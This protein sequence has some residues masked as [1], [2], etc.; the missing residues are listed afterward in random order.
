MTVSPDSDYHINTSSNHS[1][2]IQSTSSFSSRSGRTSSSPKRFASAPVSAPLFATGSGSASGGAGFFSLGES[3]IAERA[4]KLKEERSKSM[5]SPE[6]SGASTDI[7]DDNVSIVSRDESVASAIFDKASLHEFDHLLISNQAEEPENL[8]HQSLVG[9]FQRLTAQRQDASDAVTDEQRR[10]SATINFI[11]PTTK[12]KIAPSPASAP[13]MLAT[14]ASQ[15]SNLLQQQS[16]LAKRVGSTTS[17]A[18]NITNSPPLIENVYEKLTHIFKQEYG[19][20]LRSVQHKNPRTGETNTVRSLPVRPVLTMAG[21]NRAVA[22]ESTAWG[23][24]SGMMPV[25]DPSEWHTGPLCHVYIAACENVDHYRTKV[26]PSLKVFVSQLESSESNMTANQ[27]GGHSA[28]YLIVYVPLGDSGRT[29]TPKDATPSASKTPTTTGRLGFFGIG[30]RSQTEGQGDNDD[31]SKNSVDSAEIEA[32]NNDDSD[33]EA[34]GLNVLMALNHL[35]KAERALYKKIVTNFPNG[36]VC[37]LSTES[38]EK[39]FDSE[40]MLATRVQE[41]NVF[42]RLLGQV[43]VNGFHDRVRRYKAELKRLD[44]QRASAATAAKNY[45][46]K[47]GSPLKP[48]PY[49]FNLSHF[50]LVKESLAFS[51]EQ[52]QLPAEALLQ[53]DEFRLY[54]PDLTDKEERKVRKA[55]RKSKALTDEK[56][57]AMADAGDFLGFRKRIRTE[58]DLTAILDIMRRYLFARE[59]SLLF[60]MENP[61]EL[62]IR[63]QAFVKVMYSIVLRG[64]SDLDPADQKERTSRAATWVVQFSWDICCAAREYLASANSEEPS[65]QK[66]DEAAAA[67]LSDILEVARLFLIQLAKDHPTTL[68]AFTKRRKNFPRDFLRPWEPWKPCE[69]PPSESSTPKAQTSTKDR[70][71]LITY[72]DIQTSLERFDEAYLQLCGVIIDSRQIAKHHRL[73][74]RIQAEV[75]EY[76]ASKGDLVKAAASFSKIVKMYRLDH[77]DRSHF[78]RVFRLAYCQRTSVEPTLYLKT[79][80]SCFSPRSAVVAPKRALEALFEDLKKVIEHP[81][82]G[83]ARYSRLLFIETSLSVEA[84]K[85]QSGRILDQ[86]EVEKRICSVGETLKL[87]FSIKSHLPGAIELTSVKL[88]AVTAE[89]FKKILAK[90]DAVQE[91]DAAKVLSLSSPIQINP[92]K[93]DFAFEWS[94]PRSGQYILSTVEILWKQGYFY[95]DSM[96]LQEPLLSI[97][98]EPN[99]PTHSISMEPTEL[100]PGHDQEVKISFEAGADVVSS[101]KLILSG[102]DGIQLIPPNSSEWQQDW[103]ADLDPLKPGQKHEITAQVRCALN[104]TKSS[105]DDS[106]DDKKRGLFAKALTS[107]LYAPTAEEEK[108]ETMESTLEAFSPLLEKPTLS[109][110]SVETQWIQANER[111]L[112]SIVVASNTQNQYVVEEWN[113]ELASPMAILGETDLNKGLLQRSVWEG[114]QLSFVFECT[115]DQNNTANSNKESKMRLKLNGEDGKNFWIGLPLDLDG[116]GTIP[117]T[118]SPTESLCADLTLDTDQG[119]VG[120]P[121]S[122]TFA[123]DTSS[124]AT[125]RL[126]YSIDCPGGHWLLGGKVSGIIANSGAQ[127]LSCVGIPVIPGVLEDFPVISLESL[128]TSGVTAPIKVECQHPET[129]QSMPMTKVTAIAMPRYEER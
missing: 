93:N 124:F 57:Q 50:F 9:G 108:A 51:Y 88:F 48:N 78:W 1:R 29:Y 92:G 22:N 95:Y 49:A 110:E 72:A 126:V 39:V 101:V 55:R 103:F 3:G 81:S 127:K 119:L 86:K 6:K 115:V 91:E 47:S 19:S 94:P 123:F 46:G 129:F 97:E 105:D 43:L 17:Q 116:F 96:D 8:L 20:T 80:C 54:M 82:I 113:L 44:A 70:Q 11:D 64:I 68:E 32:G 125:S 31:Q 37:V 41:W 87:P 42:N 120:D 28:D 99:E 59:L 107:F 73:S 18:S 98:V 4:R 30:R 14:T 40:E 118:P 63:C 33:N 21:S 58:Y 109:V 90:G 121:L 10:Y 77:W 53:Y 114:D 106:V 61:V 76:Y 13:P 25:S 65:K 24:T 117:T 111:F 60:R 122:M 104:S 71:F 67:K 56:L 85:S 2:R 66:M 27:Q 38:L 79:L 7:A 45:A 89:T 102:T 23:A 16:M 26:R 112:L 52:M 12:P 100:V 69:S 5:T 35:S 128:D 36:K 74:S 83:N 34:S 15:P 62:M 75:G 84:G